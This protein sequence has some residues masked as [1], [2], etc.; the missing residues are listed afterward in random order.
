MRQRS[1]QR[2]RVMKVKM[3]LTARQH[4]SSS[5]SPLFPAVK[6]GTR[7][8]NKQETCFMCESADIMSHPSRRRVCTTSSPSPLSS[9]SGS[10]SGGCRRCSPSFLTSSFQLLALI[11]LVIILKS[12][13][14]SY[15]LLSFSLF[16]LH[17][18]QRLLAS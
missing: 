2:K 13:L 5:S 17:C 8:A 6:G 18:R 12:S 16:S 4:L 15:R 10:S 14:G 7:K 1:E 9:S 3:K 11:S